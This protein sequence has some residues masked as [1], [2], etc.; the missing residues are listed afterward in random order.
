MK[1][2]LVACTALLLGAST[3]A[4]AEELHHASE[5]RLSIHAIGATVTQVTT[6]QGQQYSETYRVRP[7]HTLTLVE[8]NP[9]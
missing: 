9:L 2:I 5:G 4:F 6:D 3:L 8:R 1:R 7:D